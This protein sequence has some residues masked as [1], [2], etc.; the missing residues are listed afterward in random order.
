MLSLL[1]RADASLARKDAKLRRWTPDMD[2]Q[3]SIQKSVM[4]VTRKGRSF[5]SVP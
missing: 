4:S 5:H 1:T 2:A 3:L